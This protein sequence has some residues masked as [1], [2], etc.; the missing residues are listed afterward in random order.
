MTAAPPDLPLDVTSVTDTATPEAVGASP[1]RL[2]LARLRRNRVALVAAGCLAVIVLACIAAP[3]YAHYVSQTDPFRSNVNGTTVVHGHR[4]AVVP[5]NQSGLGS[6]PIGPTLTAH[7][8]LGADSQ[9]RDVAAR[10]LYGGRTSLI[11][12]VGAAL[13]TSAVATI[14]A[15]VAGFYGGVL[16]S[17]ISRLLD[18]LWAFPVY[19]VAIAL[20]T[21]LLLQGLRIGPLNVNPNS[22]WL[23]TLIIAVIYIPYLARPIR[24]E[25]LS[26]RRREFVECALGQGASSWRLM[27]GEL[28]PNVVP[29]VLVFM[30]LLIATNILTES[31][32]SYLSIGIQPPNASWGTLITDGQDLLYTRPWVSIAPGLMLV[33]VIILLNV[34]GDGVRDAIDP[35]GHLPRLTRRRRRRRPQP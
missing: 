21:V 27:L 31:S 15:L 19:L 35:R 32:L 3:L 17:G 30:P 14:V 8:V 24:G 34:I 12:G 2:V 6:T 28:L 25:V 13:I 11:V 4:E 29:T 26:L 20:S 22:P 1:R 5:A 23:P 10:L 16:D 33:A 7:Y 18:L 9:G